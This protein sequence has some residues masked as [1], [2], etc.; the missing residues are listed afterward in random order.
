[1]PIAE[2]RVHGCN[3]RQEQLICVYLPVPAIFPTD[4]P[5]FPTKIIEVEHLI[6]VSNTQSYVR[7]AMC[8]TVTEPLTLTYAIIR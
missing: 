3:A 1:M 7:H 2:H 4:V 6:R 8:C 5:T